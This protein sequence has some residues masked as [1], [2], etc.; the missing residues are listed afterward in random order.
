MLMLFPCGKQI[1]NRELVFPATTHSLLQL[2]LLRVA[3][4]QAG[5]QALSTQ[6]PAES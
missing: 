3:P 6:E 4:P 1:K 2:L 5:L